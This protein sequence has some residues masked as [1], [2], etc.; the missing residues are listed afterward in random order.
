MSG[1][2]IG[3]GEAG[4][5]IGRGLREAGVES[6]AAYDLHAGTPGLME[7]ICRHSAESGVGLVNSAEELAAASDILLSTVVADAA[8]DA[9]RQTGPFLGSRHLYAD[10]NSVSPDTKRSLES[11]VTPTGARFVE[12]T[13]M[14][15]VP[16]RG[17]RAP[18]LLAGPSAADLE[19]T[20]APFGM[21]MEVVSDQVG[22]AAAIKLCRSIVVKGLEALMVECALAACHFGADERVFASLGESFPGLDWGT[23]AGYMT[24]RVAMHGE[25]RAREMDQAA[26]MLEAIGIEPIMAR[27]AARRQDWCARLGLGDSFSGDPP[28]DYREIVRAVLALTRSDRAGGAVASSATQDPHN[29]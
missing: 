2:S 16:P 5:H 29:T 22:A 6:V 14:S 19:R 12:A 4:F 20:M 17:H 26:D 8:M 13:I 28:E 3:F 23:L 11:I 24:S 10:L 7:R 9:A 15:P 25:R 27:A 1:P 18:M 21:R